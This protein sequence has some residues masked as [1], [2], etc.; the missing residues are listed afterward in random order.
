M[1]ILKTDFSEMIVRIKSIFDANLYTHDKL[2]CFCE[3]LKK[4][5]HFR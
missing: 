2:L 5:V 3:N 4:M 1:E